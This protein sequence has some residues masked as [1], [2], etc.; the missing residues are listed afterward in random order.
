M[1]SV[2]ADSVW[3]GFPTPSNITCWSEEVTP[4]VIVICAASHII[5]WGRVCTNGGR[6]PGIFT[7]GPLTGGWLGN[8]ES[9]SHLPINELGRYV[10]P[11]PPKYGPG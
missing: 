1:G 2:G 3:G 5:H 10:P 11:I 8:H 6:A 7:D 9:R 4:A